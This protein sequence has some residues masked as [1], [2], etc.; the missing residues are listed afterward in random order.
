M[1]HQK[2]KVKQTIVAPGNL[3]INTFLLLP[4]TKNSTEEVIKTQSQ[5]TAKFDRIE[6]RLHSYSDMHLLQPP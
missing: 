1:N 2:L 6:V 4:L 3:I 5:Q